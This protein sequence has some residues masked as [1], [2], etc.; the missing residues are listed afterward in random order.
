MFEIREDRFRRREMADRLKIAFATAASG[1]LGLGAAWLAAGTTGATIYAGA[2][3]YALFKER[4]IS[5][6]TREIY[7]NGSFLINQFEEVAENA[8]RMAEKVKIKPPPVFYSEHLM[9][10]DNACTDGVNV[11]MGLN[12]AQ[13]PTA[14]ETLTTLAHEIGHI[15]N[16][17]SERNHILHAFELAT[18]NSATVLLIGSFAAGPE[19]MRPILGFVWAM[20]VLGIGHHLLQ[21]TVRKL[22]EF[23]ADRLGVRISNCPLDMAMD[24]YNSPSTYPNSESCTLLQKFIRPH[25]PDSHRIKAIVQICKRVPDPVSGP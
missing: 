13:N 22:Q 12:Y 21:K 8:G 25:P 4:R 3:F 7:T 20:P 15:K 9:T 11:I 18:Y 1:G 10:P 23:R 5:A 14:L 24:L 6:K 16:R 17:D 19:E 2:A